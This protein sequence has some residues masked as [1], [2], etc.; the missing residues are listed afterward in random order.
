MHIQFVKL[1]MHQTNIL[2]LVLC[3]NDQLIYDVTSS[4]QIGHSDHSVVDN[5]NR[6]M[7]CG[8]HTAMSVMLFRRITKKI[9]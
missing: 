1:P 9:L 6:C 5:W 3:D 2:D 8:F 7:S 4:R